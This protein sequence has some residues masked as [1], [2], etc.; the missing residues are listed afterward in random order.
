M[1][2]ILGLAGFA[3]PP[4]SPGARWLR[5]PHLLLRYNGIL[6]LAAAD[7]LTGRYEASW[8]RNTFTD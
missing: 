5:G 2:V 3:F 1:V 6:L 8:G 7:G 4:G